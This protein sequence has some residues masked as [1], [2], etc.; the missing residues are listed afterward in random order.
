MI[1]NFSSEV[2]HAVLSDVDRHIA[3]VIFHPAQRS[4]YTPR[5]NIHPRWRRTAQ[6]QLPTRHRASMYSL[7]FCVRFLLPEH[8]QRK[9]AVQ[10]TAVMLRTPPVDGQSQA[11]QPRPLS[12]YGAQFWE[13]PRY[14][15]VSGQQCA[16]TPPSRPFHYVVISQ[17]GRKLVTRVRVMLP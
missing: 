1:I 17:D 5:Y 13:C 14:P 2:G 9:P 16:Q 12:I 7:T 15:P 8:N 4:T 3:V 11:S 10:A 6:K